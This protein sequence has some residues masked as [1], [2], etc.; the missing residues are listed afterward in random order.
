MNIQS[1]KDL[2]NAWKQ[3]DARL[4]LAIKTSETTEE[5]LNHQTVWWRLRR[6]IGELQSLLNE[7]T[8]TAKGQGDLSE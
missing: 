6:C 1:I 4:V 2:L 7:A 8:L 5:R 3:E